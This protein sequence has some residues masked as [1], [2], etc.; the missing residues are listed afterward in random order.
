MKTPVVGFVHDW[1]N[2]MR[3]GEKC[4]EAML[5]VYP[6]S[7]IYTLFCERAR[8]SKKIASHPIHTSFLQGFPGIN[9]VYRH[10]L[11][12]LPKAVESLRPAPCEVL[13]SMS[14][15]VAKSAHKP[16]GSKHICYLFTP[17]RYAWC[18][19]DEYFSGR[20]RMTQAA[21]RMALERL[22]KWDYETTPRVDQFIAISK[23]VAQRVHDF[24]GREASVIYPPVETDFYTPDPLIPREDFYLVLSALVPYKRLDL[25]IRAMSRAN[26]RLIVIGEGPERKRLEKMAGPSVEFLGWRSDGDLLAYYRRARALLF[27]GEEDFGIVPVEMQACGGAVIGLG[28]GGLLETVRAGQTGVFFQEPTE[29]SLLEAVDTFE[30]QS[31]DPLRSR[32][33][34]LRFSRQRFVSELSRAIENASG[35]SGGVS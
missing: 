22:K 3:G 12:I 19:F 21:I 6:G 15:C 13:L 27:P 17:V 8:I 25:A 20:N 26:K 1:L 33:N 5:D 34:A 9:R 10:L 16:K 31:W 30:A 23:H 29:Q 32:E 14:H 2:G 11:P 18:Q 28:R 35:F 24:Y 7:P 4:L